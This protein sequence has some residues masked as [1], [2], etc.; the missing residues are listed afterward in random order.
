MTDLIIKTAC[1]CILDVEPNVCA[2][3]SLLGN[4]EINTHNISG[5][6]LKKKDT[7]LKVLPGNDDELS[8]D[9]T[10]INSV[11]ITVPEVD[12]ILDRCCCSRKLTLVVCRGSC[13]WLRGF[14]DLF[15]QI[16]C[17]CEGQITSIDSNGNFI[18][19]KLNIYMNPD[20]YNQSLVEGFQV[21][22]RLKIY[23][24]YNGIISGYI[25]KNCQVTKP[26]SE[27]L[28][29]A[30]IIQL[31]PIPKNT[32]RRID[33][34]RSSEAY[35]I[36][37]EQIMNHDHEPVPKRRNELGC[38]RC[39]NGR[40]IWLSP[41]EHVLCYTCAVQLSQEYDSHLLPP[42]FCCPKIHCRK[43]VLDIH[44]YPD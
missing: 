37:S 27:C 36:L 12:V 15:P 39:H 32:Q 17:H 29:K 41:C 2:Y 23:Y 35:K 34:A 20:Y 18:V 44:K 14:D 33:Q 6:K 16:D 5:Y 43:K 40:D 10:M 38:V 31:K 21:I 11:T 22:D 28:G 42:F 7:T 9:K 19:R 25:E 1:N 30:A 24:Q 8:W 26:G 4:N 13:I 3:K